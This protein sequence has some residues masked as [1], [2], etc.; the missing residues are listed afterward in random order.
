MLA[1]GDADIGLIAYEMAMLVNRVGQYLHAVP[2]A[3]DGSSRPMRAMTAT[4]P[5]S[6]HWLDEDAGPVVRPVRD[7]R[8]PGP[9]GHRRFDLVALRAW[10]TR[11]RRRPATGPA[12]GAPR[13]PRGCAA[14]PVSVAELAADLDLALGVVRVLLGDLL[15]G[16]LIAMYEPARPPRNLP[17]DDILKAVIN[18]LR[19]L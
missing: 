18:G 3:A 12:A 4:G 5:S 9:A 2:A 17:D 10:P 14:S 8:R 15:A 19:A 13:D 1:G 6:T 16:G 11:R 7:D